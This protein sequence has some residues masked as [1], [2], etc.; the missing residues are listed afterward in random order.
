M[1][2]MILDVRIPVAISDVEVTCHDHRASDVSC[3]VS[4]YLKGRLITVRINVDDEIDILSVVEV[5]D[6]D[7]PVVYEVV[8]EGEP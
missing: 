3:I 1:Y 6:V 5:D 4:K 2:G 7:V 8:P